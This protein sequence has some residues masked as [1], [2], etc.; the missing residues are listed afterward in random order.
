MRNKGAHG[1][2][3]T[4]MI[5]SRKRHVRL[6]TPL[7]E[8]GQLRKAARKGQLPGMSANDLE[9]SVQA[10]EQTVR[11]LKVFTDIARAINSSAFSSLPEKLAALEA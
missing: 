4:T 6:T 3:T 9:R 10:V 11:N 7:S 2:M 8:Y 5:R 1:Q